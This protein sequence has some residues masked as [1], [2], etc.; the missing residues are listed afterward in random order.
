MVEM[1]SPSLSPSEFA[2]GAAAWA[3]TSI[4]CRNICSLITGGP[5]SIPSGSM[6]WSANGWLT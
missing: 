5:I 2:R 3:P 6:C 4:P 1:F